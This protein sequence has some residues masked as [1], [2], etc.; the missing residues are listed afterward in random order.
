[1]SSHCNRY[2]SCGC[3]SYMGTKCQLPAD[4]PRLQQ[5]E[6]E[7][8]INSPDWH[9]VEE[10]KQAVAEEFE[11]RER[12]GK[13]KKPHKKHHYQSNLQPPKKKRKK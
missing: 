8:D 11:R 6:E 5:K 7:I 12:G 3:N 9:G 13:S 10:H 2:P 4:D 1:M